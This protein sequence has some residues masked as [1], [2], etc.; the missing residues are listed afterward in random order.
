MVAE[1][2][3]KK[4]KHVLEA[5]DELVKGVAEKSADLFYEDTYTHPQLLLAQL[6][7]RF[8]DTVRQIVREEVVAALKTSQTIE[9]YTQ[10]ETAALLKISEPT[11]IERRKKRRDTSL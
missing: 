10:K 11:L 5:I 2:F 3:D 9:S 8:E 6:L 1:V 7:K 4:H